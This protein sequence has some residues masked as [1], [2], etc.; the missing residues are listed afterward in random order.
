MTEPRLDKGLHLHFDPISGVAGDMTVAALVHA[1]V[2]ESVVKK[3]IAAISVKGLKV[4]FEPRRKGAFMGLG[5]VV[6]W[7]GKE[8]DHDHDHEHEHGHE[9]DHAHGHGHHHVHNQDHAHVH[10]SV[11]EKKPTAKKHEHAHAHRPYSEIQKLLKKASLDA[12]T[13]ALAAEIFERIARAEAELHGISIDRIAFHEVGAW[14]S[15][16]DIIGAAAALAWLAPAA[17]SSSP[18]VVGTGTIRT[19]HGLMPVPAPATASILRGIPV[20]QEGLGELT[21]PTGAAILATVV[22]KFGSAPPMILAAQGFGAGTKEFPDRSNVL[23]VLLGQP[24]GVS[25]APSAPEVVCLSA[26]LDD[27]NPQL[28]E[29]L[30]TALFA[31]GAL[32][33][34]NTPIQ[35]KKGR[36]AFCVSALCDPEGVEAVEAAFFIHSTTIGVRRQ[37]FQRSVLDRS[38]LKVK[39]ELGEIAVKVAGKHGEILGV[40]PEFEDCRKLA[41]QR[42]LPIRTVLTVAQ[43][44]AHAALGKPRRRRR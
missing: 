11:H 25:H 13:K 40:T 28:M 27:M 8:S 35:M 32:D 23:R 33:V 12:S 15:I 39:T 22:S 34:W 9:P 31:A 2:P 26:N 14:D 10:A 36:P 42:G 7:P 43:A 21:T 24:V 6:V 16:A 3:A 20:R 29:P 37:S 4:A 18:L 38:T 30:M 41:E 19:A 5:F 17:I 44:A 1:G